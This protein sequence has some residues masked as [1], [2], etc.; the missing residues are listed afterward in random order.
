MTV[1]L[2]SL[3]ADLTREAEGDWI[4]YPEWPGVAFQVRSL[5]TPAYRIA[6]DQAAQAAAR[7]HKGR[8]IPPDEIRETAGR[9]YAEHILVGWRGLDV[10]YTPEGAREVLMDPGYREVLG[11]VE[12]CAAR[13]GEVDAEIV[14]EARG[15]SPG[16]SGTN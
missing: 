5:Q 16:A 11:A 15:N 4:E 8:S 10:D 2:S 1:K 3:R 12:W 6:R 9:L 7:R 13:M 14:E